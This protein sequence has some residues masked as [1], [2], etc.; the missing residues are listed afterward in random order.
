MPKGIPVATVAIGSTGAI[1]AA[2]L[3]AQILGIESESISKDLK[4]VRNK[5]EQSIGEINKELGS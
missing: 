1:N 3:S 5:A 4:E 2:Y